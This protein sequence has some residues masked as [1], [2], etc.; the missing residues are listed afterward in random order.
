MHLESLMCELE[1][2]Q[3]QTNKEANNGQRLNG[4]S[5]I[6][7]L[8]PLNASRRASRN[9]FGRIFR[10]LGGVRSEPGVR[11]VL[12]PHG[13]SVFF[14]IYRQ[15]IMTDSS[16]LSPVTLNSSNYRAL[17]AIVVAVAFFCFGFFLILM[18]MPYGWIFKKVL[19]LRASPF[20]KWH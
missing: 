9:E 3:K 5:A 13:D 4:Y 20:L 1:D 16:Y 14:Q 12:S 10:K 15:L 11:I 8:T 2:W 7:S 6:D 18:S 17:A 19:S